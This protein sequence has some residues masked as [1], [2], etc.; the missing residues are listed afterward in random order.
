[1]TLLK[2]LCLGAVALGALA[3][4]NGAAIAGATLD[5]ITQK[6][7]MVVATAANWPPQSFMNKDNQLD[8]FD[9]EVAK[10][11]ARRLGAT[12]R[13]ITP[14]WGIITAGNWNGR[15]DISV[16]SMTPTTGRTRV[17]DFSAIYYYTPYV[18]AVHKTSKLDNRAALNGKTIGVEGGTTSE[19]YING[20]LK[21]DAVGVP[22]FTAD[23]KPGT[24]K[25]YGDSVGPLDDLRLGDGVRVDAIVSALPTVE[26]AVKRG[27]PIRVINDKPAYHEPLAIAIDKGDAELNAKL[28]EIVA[29][30]KADGTLKSLS[31]KWYGM[32]Y[33]VAK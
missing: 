13:F 23:V 3:I 11:I 28:T 14:E 4:S 30:L 26:A 10:E 29:A 21:I 12:A 15:W 31:E 33:T 9:V 20:K 27:Y 32:D 19:D 7:E 18:F 25:T 8:G 2:S 17:L 24:V 6:K 16:G 22:E 5:R 1:M